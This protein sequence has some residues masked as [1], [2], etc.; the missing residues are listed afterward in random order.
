MPLKEYRKNEAKYVMLPG[1]RDC[2]MLGGETMA[3]LRECVE[4]SPLN[5]IE[6]GDRS[7]HHYQWGYLP[8]Y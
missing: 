1:L 2:V 8:V 3:G 5:R 4:T 6:W 7:G